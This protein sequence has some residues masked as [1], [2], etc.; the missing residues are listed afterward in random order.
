[1][2]TESDPTVISREDRVYRAKLAEFAERY[3]DVVSIM[4]EMIVFFTGDEINVDLTAEERKLISFAYKKLVT[5]RRSSLIFL[6]KKEEEEENEE[7]LKLI[8][9]YKG[10]IKAELEGICNRILELLD[11]Y[12]IPMVTTSESR[13][14]FYKMM[15]DYNRYLAEIKAG[16]ERKEAAMKT[17][18]AYEEAQ[19]TASCHL[20]P[21]DPIRLGLALNCSVFHY[22]IL[23]QKEK[24]I[25]I[26]QQAFQEAA[27]DL[28][29]LARG[30][31]TY[32]E[33]LDIIKLLRRNFTKWISDGKKLDGQSTS[34]NQPVPVE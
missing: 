19:K 7:K 5:T 32:T 16:D 33:R 21:S 15:G 28:N 22:E 30:D 9:A 20:G 3:D 25:R 27:V 12:L 31:P 8:K 2:A 4:E 34:G 29:K 17:L 24:G 26:A 10:E 18:E 1:M 13:V 23:N 6:S 14:F 11:E